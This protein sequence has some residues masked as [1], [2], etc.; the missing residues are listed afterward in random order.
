MKVT[1]QTPV[2]EKLLLV[3]MG[4]QAEGLAWADP[5]ARTP[6]G[7]RRKKGSS[8]LGYHLAA[9]E[10]ELPSFCFCLSTNWVKLLITSKS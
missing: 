6:I 1:L 10:R 7:A 2:P 3:S 5:G 4:G 9:V 8:Y